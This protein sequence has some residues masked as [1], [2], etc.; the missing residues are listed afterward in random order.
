MDC[1]LK[2]AVS[3]LRTDGASGGI[4]CLWTGGHCL[5]C[6]DC[7]TRRKD[8]ET[9]FSEGFLKTAGRFDELPDGHRADYFRAKAIRNR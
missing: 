8:Q 5:P 1:P 9:R 7:E 4:G 2:H 6:S 3:N